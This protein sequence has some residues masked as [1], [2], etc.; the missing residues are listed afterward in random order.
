MKLSL[1]ILIFLTMLSCTMYKDGK[2]YEYKPEHWE[3]SEWKVGEW[4]E[5]K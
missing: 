2:A 1:V 5:K 4:K 3:G